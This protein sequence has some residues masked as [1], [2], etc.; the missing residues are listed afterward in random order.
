MTDPTNAPPAKDFSKKRTPIRFVIDGDTFEAA[1]AIA[2]ETLCEFAGLY[3]Q[4]S[5]A[6]GLAE[7]YR[8]LTT[9]LEM[10][11]MPDS[12][13]RLHERLGDR[14]EPIELDQLSSVVEWLL[15]AYGLRPTQLP[16]PS[17]GGEPSPPPGT[18]STESTV[19]AGSTFSP[20]PPPVS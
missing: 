13:Q 7:T 14:V 11:L 6:K 3:E 10:T 20:S 16:S 12:W 5:G 1:P 9:V 2:A 4:A 8:L 18:S 15:E 17:S 19:P